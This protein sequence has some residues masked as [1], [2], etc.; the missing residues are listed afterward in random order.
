MGVRHF[1]LLLALAWLAAMVQL[2][3]A[4]WT[5][6]AVTLHDADD[7]MRL[8][9]VRTFLSGQGWYDLLEPRLGLSPGYLTH[10]SRLVDAGIAGLFLML[11]PLA[12]AVLAEH[13][14]II[15]WPMLWLL[16]A[17]GGVA[18]IAWRLAGRDAAILVLLLAIFDT[19][20]LQQF[21]PTRIDHHNV[22]IALA[23]VAV[24]ATVWSDRLRWTAHVAG[25]VSGLG[26]GIGLEAAHIHA[27]CGAALVLHYLFDRKAAPQMGA[28]GI[29]LALSVTLAF[30]ATVAPAHWTQSVCDH[31]AINSGVCVLIAAAGAGVMGAWLPDERRWVRG[32][33]ILVTVGLA[34]GV[35]ALLQ[36]RCLL[37]PYGLVD[38]AI[39]PIWLDH[40]AE[41]QSWLRLMQTGPTTGMALLAFPA[42]GLIA[43]AVFAWMSDA[44]R[45]FGPL[46]AAAACLVAVLSFIAVTRNYSYAVWFSL[47]L[48][49][50]AGS[51]LFNRL[52]LTKPA[53]RLLPGL[54]ITPTAVTLGAIGVASA[55]GIG[56]VLDLNSSER[57]ACVRKD[58]YAALARL[59]KGLLVANELEWG[60][61]LLAWTPHAVLAA[62]YHRL[63]AS[64]LAADRIF[65]D[66]PEAAHR[67]LDRLNVTYV[68]TC[69]SRGAVGLTGKARDASL[70]NHLQAGKI[71]DFLE[72]LPPFG[73]A[74]SVYRVRR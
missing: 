29:A 23:I 53:L 16:P 46:L 39:R 28:Y 44:R 21:R 62:P 32:T 18:A 10:W 31:L 33:A 70:W 50:A 74:F 43:L 64:I 56:G 34:L 2:V 66:P 4:D 26:L 71:P 12:G 19:P 40:V 61:Y 73:Q 68:V 37:G 57:Q 45:Q 30:F 35:A 20:G 41:D 27:L 69:G 25:A 7:A 38:P 17:I 5:N 1:A 65:A 49:A 51:E 24:A 55:T 72:P 58:N 59:P 6:I 60:P 36:P 15:I 67:L 42:A 48:V 9:E 11:K 54:L 47:P 8:V 13:L 14:T 52:K 3:V 22:Q 63:A